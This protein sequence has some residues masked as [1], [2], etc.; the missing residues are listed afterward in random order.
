MAEETT[1]SVTTV[2]ASDGTV[3]I[4]V[5]KYE[6]LV[7]KANEQKVYYNQTVVEKTPEMA[8]QDLVHMGVFFMGGGGTMFVIGVLQFMAGHRKLNALGS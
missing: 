6:E 3:K 4:S 5:E 8:A 7:R 2:K 1:E